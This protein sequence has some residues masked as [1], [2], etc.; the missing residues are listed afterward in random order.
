MQ[1]LFVVFGRNYIKKRYVNLILCMALAL[2]YINEK[3]DL[4]YNYE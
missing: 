1:T 3:F 2:Y 4:F